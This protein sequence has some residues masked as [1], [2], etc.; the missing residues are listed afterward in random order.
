MPEYRW[1][2]QPN[3]RRILVEVAS[4]T[5]ERKPKVTQR[6]QHRL[7]MSQEREHDATKAGKNARELREAQQNRRGRQVTLDNLGHPPR[8]DPTPPQNT[9]QVVDQ[10]PL[11]LDSV[12]LN[13]ES[14]DPPAPPAPAPEPVKAEVKPEEKQPDPLKCPVEGC[15]APLFG[16]QK[17]R[18]AHIR[19]KHKDR[20]AELLAKKES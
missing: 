4:S 19:A 13:P 12:A 10:L 7:Q 15:S 3:G 9:P 5:G 11:P 16:S 2:K 18:D 14:G 6:Q 8:E 20:A 17:G 1:E